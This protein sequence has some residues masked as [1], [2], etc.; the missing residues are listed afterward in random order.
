MKKRL[1]RLGNVSEKTKQTFS[2]KKLK[3]SNHAGIQFSVRAAAEVLG[4]EKVFKNRK[5]IETIL[6]KIIIRENQLEQL[7]GNKNTDLEIKRL[8]SEFSNQFGLIDRLKFKRTYT[9]AINELNG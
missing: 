2:R 5:Q 1:F 9:K 7:N 8:K 6:H 3:I 4:S